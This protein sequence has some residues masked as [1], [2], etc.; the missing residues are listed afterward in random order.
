MP[1]FGTWLQ[2]IR[3]VEAE[4]ISEGLLTEDGQLSG[5]MEESL[6]NGWF[7]ICLAMRYN[8]ML[9]D[10]YWSFLDEM[11]FGAFTSLEERITLLSP[12]EK[13]ELHGLYEMK[14][15]QAKGKELEDNYNSDV[16]F[17]M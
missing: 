2:S 15:E 7:W 14:V 17:W 8:S 10:I 11:F 1:R 4:M 6:T 12:E 13:E 16:L 3:G 9:D 5:H